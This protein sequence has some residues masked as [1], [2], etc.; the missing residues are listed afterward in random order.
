MALIGGIVAR[1][2]Y[3]LNLISKNHEGS[4]NAI[5]EATSEIHERINRVKDEYVRRVDLDGHIVR[6]DRSV[7]ALAAEMRSSTVTT[8]QR[9]DA[10]LAHFAS[11]KS[12]S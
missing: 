12:G 7:N 6:L 9:L 10:I 1:D 3:I 2:R 8:N 4:I 5:Q 11:Q